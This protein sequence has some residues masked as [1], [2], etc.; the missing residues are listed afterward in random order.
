MTVL[1]K[2]VFAKSG[3]DKLKEKA[4]KNSR[5]KPKLS[6]ILG[7]WNDNL[8]GDIDTIYSEFSTDQKV[9]AKSQCVELIEK[10]KLIMKPGFAYSQTEFD[11][12]FAPLDKSKFGIIEK[13]EVAQLLQQVFKKEKPPKLSADEQAAKKEKAKTKKANQVGFSDKTRLGPD[14][15]K[16]FNGDLDE[17]WARV[18]NDGNML[19]D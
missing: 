9:L 12:K 7:D 14:Y 13:W 19:L 4:E 11:R 6:A 1:L 3:S 16:R 18:D 2:K 8:T 5:N 17:I 15:L 10:V